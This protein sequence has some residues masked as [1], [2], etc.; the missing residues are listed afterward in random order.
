VKRAVVALLACGSV[1][2]LLG[3]AVVGSASAM[4]GSGA[5][6]PSATATSNIPP[7]MLALYQEAAKV[8]GS[9]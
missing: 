1:V 3:I 9:N 4:F 7:A 5:S 8:F 2:G 6:S